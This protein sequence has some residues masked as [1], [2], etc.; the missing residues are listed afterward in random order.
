MYKALNNQALSHL[1]DP[2]AP[3]IIPT[4]HFVVKMQAYLWFLDF[5]KLEWEAE[6]SAIVSC[7]TSSQFV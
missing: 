4:E 7:G 1:K 2:V 6:L 3:L 5:P